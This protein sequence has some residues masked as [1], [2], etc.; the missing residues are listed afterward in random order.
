MSSSE[1]IVGEL[2]RAKNLGHVGRTVYDRRS[3]DR[4]LDAPARDGYFT[5]AAEVGQPVFVRPQ[6]T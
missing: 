5:A 1:H 3:D 2:A 4:F 6:I